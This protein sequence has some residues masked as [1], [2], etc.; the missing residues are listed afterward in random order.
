MARILLRPAPNVAGRLR[1]A[2]RP[3]SMAGAPHLSGARRPPISQ[4]MVA[5]SSLP[6]PSL[7]SFCALLLLP[8]LAL[9]SDLPPM[10][11]GPARPSSPA[12]ELSVS[13]RASASLS[14]SLLL[15]VAGPLPSS[16]MA[17]APLLADAQPPA[18]AWVLCSGAASPAGLSELPQL[19]AL[20]RGPCSHARPCLSS[21]HVSCVEQ[22]NKN[23]H[24]S[25]CWLE[26][27]GPTTCCA[28]PAVVSSSPMAAASRSGS[29]P[30]VHSP[31]RRLLLAP[32][33]HVDLPRCC[34]TWL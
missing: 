25:L 24:A 7:S 30:Y 32:A 23:L 17:W 18:C 33:A 22:L 11:L 19:A 21:V 3:C 28:R 9:R 1:L 29:R 13:L 2:V 34:H 20:C 31:D 5:V 16:P 10:A 12:R 4:S 8:E 27:L 6:P 14:S 15:R 26:F